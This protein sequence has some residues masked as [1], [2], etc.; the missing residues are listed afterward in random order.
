MQNLRRCLNTLGIKDHQA[1]AFL[2]SSSKGGSVRLR[3]LSSIASNSPGRD[4][5]TATLRVRSDS[6][7]LCRDSRTSVCQTVRRLHDSDKSF[8]PP[9]YERSFIA[10]SHY[11]S[12]S[13]LS[14]NVNDASFAHP[15]LT[16]SYSSTSLLSLNSSSRLN[17]VILS[18]LNGGH[19]VGFR[20]A[21]SLWSGSRT[22]ED[23]SSGRSG[24]KD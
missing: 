3:T 7:A 15:S 19:D 14:F 9:A 17:S 13:G 11:R 22:R 23:D 21:F 10:Q 16:S 6:S 24:W 8:C 4:A 2:S 18:K 5:S 20:R 12:H 1:L